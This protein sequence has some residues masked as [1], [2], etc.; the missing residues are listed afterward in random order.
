[1]VE[2]GALIGAVGGIARSGARWSGEVVWE[3]PEAGKEARRWRGK[4]EDDVG[5]EWSVQA[6]VVSA[7]ACGRYYCPKYFYAFLFLCFIYAFLFHS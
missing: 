4:E 2:V 5:L 1:V 6:E 7:C 3:V